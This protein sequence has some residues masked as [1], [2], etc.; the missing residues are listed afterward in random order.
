MQDYIA[1]CLESVINQTYRDVEIIC[2]ND[3]STD[4]SMTV[5]KE[6][7]EKDDRI[8]IIHNDKNRGLGGARN[9]GL[10]AAQGEYVIFVDTD[11]KMRPD[12]AQNLLSAI[13]T[14]N[15]DMV[16]CDVYLLNNDS[17]TKLY[18]P[19]HDLLIFKNKTEFELPDDIF[20]FTY[21]WPSAWNKIYKKSI[22]DEHNLRYI[23]NILYEDHT[24]YY[25][26]LL[27][28]KNAYYLEKPL[29]IYRHARPDSIMAEVSPRIFEIFK[30]LEAVD[31]IFK[32]NCGEELRNA[33]M[34][35]LSVRL[36]WERTCAFRKIG[37]TERSFIKKSRNFLKKY[38]HKDLIYYKDWFIPEN[39]ALLDTRASIIKKYL[40][41]AEY[42]RMYMIYRFLGFKLSIKNKPLTEL[43][44]Q[45]D[46]LACRMNKIEADNMHCCGA[47]G[48]YD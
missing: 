6:Y 11:D 27:K 42:D 38:K 47:G 4:N 15:V 23:E 16:F 5:V 46:R 7:A 43:Q 44:A 25:E 21:A 31:N 37:K 19:I 40:L 41:S 1:E 28:C 36:L 29:Y 10:D 33:V 26:Y 39:I 35:R 17:S 48:H 14:N 22:I 9:A 24:F 45:M 3:F 8:R 34:P 32:V 18:K 12:M 13:E 20:L 2:V 30:I